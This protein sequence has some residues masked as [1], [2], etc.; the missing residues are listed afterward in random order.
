[1]AQGLAQL[2]GDWRTRREMLQHLAFAMH[3]RG[4][5][6]GREITEQPLIDALCAYL[7]ERRHMSQTDAEILV[8]DLVATTRQ[9]GGLLEEHAGHYRFSHLSFQEFL[10]ARYLAEVERDVSRMA[11]FFEAQDRLMDSWWRE[12]ILLTGGYLHVTAPER[13][14]DFIRRL[15]HVDASSPPQTASALAA[16]ELAS[17]TFLE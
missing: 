6:A 11:L 3:S 14:T 17:A 7:Q 2:G 12:P 4:Q 5:D 16:V 13:A 15:A 10:T 8:R 1:M 9:R